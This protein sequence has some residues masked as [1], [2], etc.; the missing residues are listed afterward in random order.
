MPVVSEDTASPNG[1]GTNEDRAKF[2][3]ALL[4]YYNQLSYDATRMAGYIYA[5]SAAQKCQQLSKA[6]A[7][8][9]M[10]LPVRLKTTN[11]AGQQ[12]KATL[13]FGELTNGSEF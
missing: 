6:A 7:N 4:G 13:N 12:A 11:S 10:S 3:G 5:W 1:T 2:Q 8:A 9:A